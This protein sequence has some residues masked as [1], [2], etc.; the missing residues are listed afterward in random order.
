MRVFNEDK[1]QELLEYDIRLG[2]LKEDK[3]FIAHHDAI[4]GQEEVGHYEVIK[5]YPNSGKDF[6]WVIDQPKIEAKEAWDEY[7][8]ILVYR[9]FTEDEQ[10][11]LLRAKRVNLLEAF[12]KWEK[13]VL[14]GREEDN[15]NI[16]QWYQ[17][18]LDLKESA[19]EKIP[20]RIKYYI[21]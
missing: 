1:T 2:T 4:Q 12:D 11:N 20:E 18:I 14:R 9:L 7:E 10:K 13:A 19:F 5:E 17:N 21:A 15:S 8:D 16:M 3:L 6:K